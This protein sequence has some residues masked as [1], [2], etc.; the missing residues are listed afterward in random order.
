MRDHKPIVIDKFNG[1]WRR[2]DIDNVPHDH[3]YTARNI[4][5]I[6]GGVRTR[7]GLDTYRA[8]GNP[9]RIY[10]YTMQTG[11]SLLVLDIFG[12]IYHVIDETTVYGPIL[13]IPE[14][15]DFGFHAWAGRAYITPF[16]TFTD[17]NGVTYQKGLENEF[18]YVYKGD[19]TAAR[20]AAGFPPVNGDLKP[21]ICFNSTQV[22]VV[23]AGG[24]AQARSGAHPQ[25]GPQRHRG[26]RLRDPG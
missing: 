7:P 11:E 20:K 6:P 26:R 13:S 21:F 16:A 10:N 19:G 1:M 14:M 24:D 8:V 25:R 3:F 15:T 12:D 18:L 5:Y 4:S 9:L 23:T 2:G 22:G 17:D